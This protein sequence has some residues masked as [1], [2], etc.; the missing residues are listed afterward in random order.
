MAILTKRDVY[1][2][3]IRSFFI[4]AVWNYERMLNIGFA[5]CLIPAAR[6]FVSRATVSS[7]LSRHLGFFNANPFIATM[8]VGAVVK[9]EE[10][11]VSEE[12]I[13]R[14]KQAL[15][16]PLGA[17][18]DRTFWG[19]VRPVSAVL[20]TVVVL[21]GGG[22]WGAIIF[23]IVF[24]VIQT[25]VRRVAFMHGY[26]SGFA[27]ARTLSGPPYREMEVWGRR[28]GGL[29]VGFLIVTAFVIAGQTSGGHHVAILIGAMAVGMIIMRR[30]L[31]M[32]F[33]FPL[34]IAGFAIVV[35]FLFRPL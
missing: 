21:I 23:L 22:W 34:C 20:G 25:L 5:F 35:R 11:G 3:I 14:F 32:S 7:F 4:Q 28:L 10:T 16:G 30:N 19:V 9:L 8:A 24:N 2:T 12:E 29:F 1:S 15:C 33:L 26:G 13:D 6:R 27:V 18:G 31:P 17:V